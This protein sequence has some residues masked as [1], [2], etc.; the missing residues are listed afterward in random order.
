LDVLDSFIEYT[1][2][3]SLCQGRALQV[4]DSLD[5]LSNLHSLL[6]LNW[7]HLAL[8][9]LLANLW[10]IAQIELGAYKDDWNAGCVMLNFRVP[11]L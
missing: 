9:E 5:V 1:L 10:V 8:S 4:L 11:L 6:V 7:R 3:I 2:Q